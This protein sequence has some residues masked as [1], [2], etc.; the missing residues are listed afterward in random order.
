MIPVESKQAD[1]CLWA[2]PLLGNIQCLDSLNF[3]Q[4]FNIRCY[5]AANESK[6]QPIEIAKQT[7]SES[8]GFQTMLLHLSVLGWL[9]QSRF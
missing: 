2:A 5:A 1:N 4:K 7:S 3:G 6:E 8:D 9:Q